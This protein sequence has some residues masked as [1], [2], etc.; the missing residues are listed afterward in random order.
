M[1]INSR[2]Q[3]VLSLV[4]KNNSSLETPQMSGFKIQNKIKNLNENQGRSNDE[5]HL[6]EVA[7]Q[8]E[9]YFLKE[10]L[11]GMRSTVQESDFIKVSNGQK[12]FQEQLDDQYAKEW[13]KKGGF[14]LADMIFDQLNQKYGEAKKINTEGPAV[15]PL[16]QS[17]VKNIK[18][19]QNS[20]LR[21]TF[22]FETAN[23]MSAIQNPYEGIL[24][25]KS[26]LEQNR[27]QLKI[28]HKNG[29]ESLIQAQGANSEKSADL[30]LGDEVKTGQNIGLASPTSPLVWSLSKS[31]SE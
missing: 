11:K 14:G 17:R 6:K 16:D 28:K 13:N 15:N 12:I 26:L 7:N 23:E 4:E 22:L 3:D 27:M 21:K 1:K 8:Y 19:L 31:V 25:E 29:L 5:A 10:L 9:Q 20:D 30:K 18:T 24:E 2:A